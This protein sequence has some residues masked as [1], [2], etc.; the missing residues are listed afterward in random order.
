[1]KKKIVIANWKM[2]LSLKET[3]ELTKEIMI[4]LKKMKDL[5]NLEIVFSPSF[6][7]LFSVKKI[8]E[9]Y[10]NL[11]EVV[12]LGAQNVFWEER[13]AYTGEVSVM[14]LK[15]LGINYIIVGHSERRNYLKEDE[16]MIHKKI[17]IVLNHN[18]IPIICV[19]EKFEERQL[20]QKDIIIIKQISS[21]LEGIN[22][23]ENNKII[24]AYEPVWVIGS[25]QAVA[26]VEAE[27][28]NRVIK[29]R[30]IDF[31]PL[32]F[33]EKNVRLI[34]GGSVD[35]NN[36]RGFMEKENIDGVLVGGA[37]LKAKDFL[38]ILLEILKI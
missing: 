36:I 28:T 7:A 32:D 25:G 10:P 18:L 14:M 1:M 37:S 33:V 16:E 11:K 2:S 27:Y 8:I 30:L 29:Q 20:G 4:G 12:Y 13:G 15:E 21:A 5:S 31:L 22:F 35:K 3:E 19:G 6:P 26:P 24:V 34:Y 17:R 23:N 38:E 9:Q